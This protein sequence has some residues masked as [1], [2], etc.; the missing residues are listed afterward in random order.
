[1]KIS[2][3][4]LALEPSEG[5]LPKSEDESGLI[6]E[7]FSVTVKRLEFESKGPAHQ[8]GCLPCAEKAIRQNMRNTSRVHVARGLPADSGLCPT[9]P[10]VTALA[11]LWLSSFEGA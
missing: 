9:T 11:K 7:G 3:T 5:S 2:I 8:V 1:M 6:G 4:S 10:H